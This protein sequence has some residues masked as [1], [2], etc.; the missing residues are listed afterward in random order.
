MSKRKTNNRPQKPNHTG[1]NEGSRRFVQ[2]DFKLLSSA[3]YSCLS[4]NA[5]SLLVEL[6]MIFNG[7]NNG[8]LYL[9]VRDAAARMGVADLGVAIRAFA[10]LTEAGFLEVAKES[11]FEVKAAENSRARCWRLT[12]HAWPECTNKRRR[13]PT[14]EWREYLPPTGKASKRADKRL[15]ALAAYKKAESAG[16][17]PVRD[18]RTTAVESQDNP[19]KPVMDSR[20]AKS[21]TPAKVPKLVVRDSS[22]HIH[23]T[24]GRCWASGLDWSKVTSQTIQ[25]RIGQLRLA[26]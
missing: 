19:V 24:T 6:L 22:T 9:S 18:S 7:N 4:S 8:S 5:R 21:K 1:R 26:A 17:L 16:H 12:N 14:H 11:H 23:I 3:A 15:R 20:T 2:L 25:T 10:E 13:P